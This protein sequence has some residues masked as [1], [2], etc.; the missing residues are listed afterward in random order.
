MSCSPY[1]DQCTKYMGRPVGIRTRDGHMHRGVIT[2]VN[3]SHV[4]I[5]PLGNRNLG[6]FGYGFGGGFGGGYGGFGGAYGGGYGGR[7]YGV[8]LGAIAALTL[9]AF[10]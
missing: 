5:R 7:G 6:G 8:A 3:N 9:L 1:F 4:F 10:W 2:N